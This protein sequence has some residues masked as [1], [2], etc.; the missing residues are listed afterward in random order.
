TPTTGGLL[1]AVDGQ[2]D[3]TVARK[4]FWRGNFLFVVDPSIGAAGF[5]RFRPIDNQSGVWRKAKNKEL[6]DYSPTDQYAGGVE[7]FYD[8]MDDVLPPEPL[9]PTQALLETI[10]AF[11]EQVKT[12]AHSVDN[13]RKFLASGKPPADMPQGATIF[14]TQG[15]WEDFSTPSRDM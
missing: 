9:D 13:G 1:F 15:A 8:K 6:P 5:K 2:P 4:R 3:G 14:E 7:G 11:E 10:D 12:R